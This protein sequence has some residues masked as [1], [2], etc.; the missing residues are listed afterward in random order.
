MLGSKEG[1][2]IKHMFGS[3]GEGKDFITNLPFYPYN[4]INVS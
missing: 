2:L 4:L 3:Q 1:N